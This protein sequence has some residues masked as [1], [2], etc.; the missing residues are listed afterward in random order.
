MV[1][2]FPNYETTFGGLTEGIA[3]TEPTGLPPEVRSREYEGTGAAATLPTAPATQDA[4]PLELSDTSV[5]AAPV[6]TETPETPLIAPPPTAPVGPV[7]DQAAITVNPYS[8]PGGAD[9]YGTLFNP[10]TT[11][12][13]E[14]RES[15]GEAVTTFGGA[16]GA[17]PEFGQ[18]Q[19]DL[20]EQA[21]GRAPEGLTDDQAGDPNFVAAYDEQLNAYNQSWEDASAL[22]SNQYQGPTTLGGPTGG[23]TGD[24]YLQLVS[25]VEGLRDMSTTLESV[26]GIEALLA[27][28]NPGV[29]PGI[30]REEA[31]R[32]IQDPLWREAAADY[33][34]QVSGA[35]ANRITDCLLARIIAQDGI[36]GIRLL[37]TDNSLVASCQVLTCASGAIDGFLVQG[38][39]GNEATG[40]ILLDCRA[41]DLTTTNNLARGIRF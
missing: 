27:K 13:G 28:S 40:N 2:V 19:I 16:V 20:I 11:A 17:Y 1:Q 23:L 37:H 6:G 33:R 3:P 22:L 36:Q 29:A 39:G 34:N 41:S 10:F 35:A 30:L 12:L 26:A 5:T 4:Q 21:I 14:Q 18:E 31:L 15:L 24:Q 9:Q 8:A 38:S 7:A 25:G 32:L